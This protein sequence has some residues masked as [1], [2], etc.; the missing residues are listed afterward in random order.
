M[1]KCCTCKYRGIVPGDAHIC[2]EYPGNET[3]M[4]DLFSMK[5]QENIIKLNIKANPYAIQRGWFLY[6]INFD[7]NWLENCDGYVE[8]I[9]N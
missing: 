1:S 2:C 8:Q 7:P 4:F 9:Q 3:S 6:P 5:N